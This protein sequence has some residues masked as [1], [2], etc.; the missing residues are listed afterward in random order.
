MTAVIRP[1]RVTD[2]RGILLCLERFLHDQR[3][4]QSYTNHYNKFDFNTEKVYNMLMK[5]V[6]DPKFFLDIIEEPGPQIRGGL[7]GEIMPLI[8]SD[9]LIAYDHIL[10]ID[11]GF[12]N[13][14]A[15]LRMIL[16]YKTWAKDEGAVAWR[17]C[18]TTGFKQEQ[19]AKLCQKL[20][21]KQIGIDFEGEL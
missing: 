5:R 14:K 13:N 4:Q 21:M 7:C 6:D 15:L 9:E 17:L 8:F 2:I 16:R 18:S 11:P 12:K 19:F 20:K 3:T 10:Y 1:Y